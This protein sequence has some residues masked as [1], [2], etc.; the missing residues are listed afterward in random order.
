MTAPPRRILVLGGG[1]VGAATAFHLTR[2]GVRSVTLLERATIASG[3]T[4]RGAGIVTFQG[5]DP[6]DL[7]LVRESAQQYRTLLEA[8]GRADYRPNGGLRVARTQA[9]ADWL[10]RVGRVLDDERIPAHR[11]GAAEVSD[12]VPWADWDDVVAGLYTSS[13]ATFDATEAADEFVA[14]ARAGGAEVRTDVGQP[15]VTRRGEEWVVTSSAGRW[16]A[17]GLVVCAGPWTK[18]VLGPLGFHLPLSPFR[19][20]LVIVRPNPLVATFPTVHDLDLGCYLRPFAPGRIAVGD[21]TEPREADPDAACVPDATWLSR[22]RD[23][24]RALAPGRGE[25]VS[26]AAVC[27]LCVAT[28]DRFP[29]VGQV[30]AASGLYVAA[31]FNGFGSMRAPALGRRLAEAIVTDAWSS[32]GPAD[33]RRFS[34]SPS[35]FDPRPEF[36][37]EPV[38][39]A[40]PRMGPEPAGS[41]T[42]EADPWGTEELRFASLP[43][44]QAV[45]TLRL[46]PLSDWFDPFLRRFLKDALRVGGTAE[47]ALAGEA[48]RGVHLTSPVEDVGSV[49][50]RTPRVADHYLRRLGRGGLYT[51]SAWAPGGDAILVLA[52]DLRDWRFEGAIRNPV[53]LADG[54]DLPQVRELL[55]EVGGEVDDRWW[56][57][58]PR[59]DELCFLCEVDGR[60]AGVSWASVEGRFARGHSFAVRPRFRGLGVG[61]DLLHARMLWLQS[62]GIRQ[63]VSEIYEGNAASQTSAERA[64]MAVVGRMF[65]YREMRPPGPARDAA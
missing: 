10:T 35:P 36:P 42:L 15:S 64:G 34:E 39:P 22:I 5:W 50:T 61:T 49:F 40:L 51:E 58:L 44:A 53:R 56:E 6:W 3:G 14:S 65:H 45:D 4:G 30:P 43:D 62:L 60:A 46:P 13:D 20:Q 2:T 9:G 52:G 18:A 54:A 31:G 26:E 47:A 33:P 28:P 1:I 23:D 25:L 8:R 57:S 16:A 32:L 55:T 17:D 7:A 59:P 63:V 11:L 38:D 48:V 29:L 37:L 19:A 21:G 12:L 27:G 41:T 24:L